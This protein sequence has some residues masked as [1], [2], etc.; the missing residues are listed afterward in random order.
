[1]GVRRRPLGRF[2]CERALCL[3]VSSFAFAVAAGAGDFR[4]LSE[5]DTQV[6]FEV[7]VPRPVLEQVGGYVRVTIP[8]YAASGEPGEPAL[9][10]IDHLVAVPPGAVAVA[11]MLESDEQLLGRGRILPQP[12]RWFELPEGEDPLPVPRSEYREDPSIYQSVSIYPPVGAEAQA[13]RGWRYLRIAPIEIY[14]VRYD[15]EREELYW[16]SRMIVRVDFVQRSSAAAEGLPYLRAEPRWEPLYRR[17]IV[18]YGSGKQYKRAFPAPSVRRALRAGEE[19]EF[20]VRLQV[21]RSA[22][23]RV[24]FDDLG[25]R[26]D[27]IAWDDLLLEVRDYDETAP[28]ERFIEWA[29]A[30]L[31]EGDGDAWFEEGEALI[32]Y[33]EDAWDF[34]DYTP[35]EKRYVRHNVYWL[36]HAAGAGG[37]RMETIP[38]WYG[39]DLERVALYTRTIHFEENLYYMP[40]LTADEENYASGGTD[41]PGPEVITTDHYNWTNPEPQIGTVDEPIKVVTLDFPKTLSVQAVRVH[42]QGQQRLGGSQRLPHRPRL[43]FSRNAAAFDTICA[44]PDNPYYISSADSLTATVSSSYMSD[45]GWELDTG[46]NY[47]KIYI[48]SLDDPIDN[49]SGDGVGIDWVEVSLTGLFTMRRGELFV[50]WENTE[51]VQEF[52][53]YEIDEDQNDQRKEVFAFDLNDPRMPRRLDLPDSLFMPN[54]FRPGMWDVDIQFDCGPDSID[55]AFF[56]IETDAIE[57]LTGDAIAL[58]QASPLTEFS[59]EDYVAIYPRRFGNALEPLLTHREGQGHVVVRAPIEEVYNTYSG[60]RRHVDAIKAMMRHMWANSDPPPDYLLLVGDASVDIAGYALTAEDAESDTTYVPVNT[61]PGHVFMHGGYQVVSCDGWFVDDL[62]EPYEQNM[63]YAWDMHTGRLPVGSPAELSVYVDKLL[64]YEQGDPSAPWRSRILMHADDTFGIRDTYANRGEYDFINISRDGVEYI[65]ADSIF[66]HYEID[67]LYQASEMDSIVWLERCKPD[68]TQPGECLRDQHG[69]VVLQ[70]TGLT[71]NVGP[72]LDYA[73][74]TLRDRLIDSL[75]E[76]VLIWSFQG[77]G[78]RGQLTHEQI[79]EHRR[80]GEKNVHDLTNINRPFIFMGFSCHLNEYA[81]ELEGT[82]RVLDAMTET[83]LT[84]CEGELKGAIASYAS[85]DYEWVGHLLE[86]YVFRVMFSAPPQV[87]EETR[88]RLGDLLTE[89]Q[90]TVPGSDDPQRIT[91]GL[92]GDPAL[93]VGLQ[94][95]KIALVLNGEDWDP[96]LASAYV[97]HAEDD[98]LTIGIW[99]YD[100]SHVLRPE[101]TDYYGPVPD[102]L[103]IVAAEQLDDRRMLLEYKTQVQRRPYDLTITAVDQENPTG[104]GREV[105][106]PIPMSAALYEYHGGDRLLLQSGDAISD[107]ERI[108]VLLTCGATIAPEDVTVR[109]GDVQLP[110]L[111]SQV[112]EPVGAPRLWTLDFGSL[113]EVPVGAATLDVM[114][115]QRSGEELLIASTSVDVILGSIELDFVGDYVPWMP[116][117]FED[118]ATLVYRLSV[119]AGRL[120][121]RIF[122]SSGRRIFATEELGV[123]KGTNYFVWDGRDDDGD[124]VANG[125]YFYELRA[126]DQENKPVE[127]VILDKVLRV[128]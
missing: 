68:T 17:R 49:I 21:E 22:V 5:S 80:T 16:S 36:V 55:T 125:L 85:S 73:K 127:R 114:V 84:C 62:A 115:T 53:V 59:G 86:R 103:L 121:L 7:Q 1:M 82:E 105:V 28:E 120:R 101:V 14:P 128:Q 41:R 66:D 15:P 9:P 112:S 10:M 46:H 106:V 25:V 54:Q 102:S 64:N 97:S 90:L 72:S 108:S 126:W 13:V 50:P 71:I 58:R 110:M 2:G 107:A 78:N 23:Y 31:P 34:F 117:P 81:D 33:G 27:P 38:G 74:T 11:T 19:A 91:Y 113:E 63:N 37:P 104:P 96:N 6:L 70:P 118:E 44:F 47:L 3:M 48:P 24:A 98:S 45:H 109:V 88:W 61:V 42:L 89:S 69:R 95:P 93:R 92:L 124:P 100:E 94:P 29:I 76:G 122:T 20:E 99:V 26:S 56:I 119:D 79:F 116:N 12:E 123:R 32:F 87:G 51:G 67:S 35:G 75:N 18:N 39:E 52:R 4:L 8:D 83:M 77:H 43:W 40:I 30:Y 111:A 60:G 57:S 65:R